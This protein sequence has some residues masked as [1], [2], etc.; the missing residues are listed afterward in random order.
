MPEVPA[1]PAVVVGVDGSRAAIRAALWAVLMGVFLILVA[2][3]TA[4]GA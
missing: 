2:V 4:H 3:L 1:P